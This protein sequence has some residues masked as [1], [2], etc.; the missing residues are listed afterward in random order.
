MPPVGE[1]ARRA[2]RTDPRPCPTPFARLASRR[3]R[4]R[5]RTRFL[6]APN[7]ISPSGAQALAPAPPGGGGEARSA[8]ARPVEL[9]PWSR[10]PAKKP[11]GA[12]QVTRRDRRTPPRPSTTAPRGSRGVGS[13]IALPGPV[14]RREDELEAVGRQREVDLLDRRPRRWRSGDLRRSTGA[15]RSRLQAEP[16]HDSR[17]CPLAGSSRQPRPRP[18]GPATAGAAS[19][20]AVAGGCLARARGARRRCR[21]GARFGS[22][23]RQRRSSRRMRGGVAAGSGAHSGSVLSTA[24]EHVADGLASKRRGR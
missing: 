24:G 18:A 21:A 7:T 10:P 8:P 23:S 17:P 20:A 16:R 9:D 1:P 12:R 3:P 6:S 5:G 14:G 4:A 19:E 11:R 22:R 15:A 2:V 13:Q